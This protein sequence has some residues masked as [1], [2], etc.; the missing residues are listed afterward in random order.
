MERVLRVK[1]YDTNKCHDP[2]GRDSLHS[3]PLGRGEDQGSGAKFHPQ[4]L[5]PCHGP[6]LR[7]DGS[8]VTLYND[9]GTI[10]KMVPSTSG[11]PGVRDSTLLGKGPIPQGR[12]FLDPEEITPGGFLR[13]SCRDWGRYRV[14]LHPL[15]ETETWPRSGFFLHGGRRPGS[16]GCIDVG[17]ADADL[18]PRLRKRRRPIPLWVE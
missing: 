17:E 8:N 15:P 10:E 14:P 12:Y 5:W 11:R 13:N 2:T 4:A 3:V 9:E 16:A 7:F 18:F 6:Y 1:D